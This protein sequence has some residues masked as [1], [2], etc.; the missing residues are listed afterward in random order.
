MNSTNDEVEEDQ[1]LLAIHYLK[2]WFLID[3]LAAIPFDW[4]MYQSIVQDDSLGVSTA[5]SFRSFFKLHCPI[6]FVIS[7]LDCLIIFTNLYVS[8]INF[9]W[10]SQKC[11]STE[12]VPG[13]FSFQI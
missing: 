13:I 3:L 4:I 8:D 5:I 7:M 1:K 9:D 12:V 2:S 10:S 6:V 11:S